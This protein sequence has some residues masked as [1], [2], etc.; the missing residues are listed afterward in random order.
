MEELLS[1]LVK[2]IKSTKTAP[3]QI[4]LPP[5][6]PDFTD[7]KKWLIEICD[8]KTEFQWSDQQTLTRVGRFLTGVSKTWYDVWSPDVKAFQRD[9]AEA[10]P[11]KKNLGR[12]LL[13]VKIVILTTHMFFRKL[14]C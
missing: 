7:A 8:I 13:T 11:P 6:K 1:Q 12:L 14:A 10:F 5:F 4:D 2:A 9:F 3:E